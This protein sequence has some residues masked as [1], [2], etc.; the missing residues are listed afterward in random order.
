MRGVYIRKA[1]NLKRKHEE[2][3]GTTR[4]RRV[5]GVGSHRGKAAWQKEM[6]IQENIGKDGN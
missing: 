5:D 4:R 6:P 2:E 1:K 3:V